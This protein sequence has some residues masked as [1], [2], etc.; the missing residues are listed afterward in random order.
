MGLVEFK[1]GYVNLC[2]FIEN[3]GLKERTH[4]IDETLKVHPFTHFDIDSWTRIWNVQGNPLRLPWTLV[5]QNEKDA[6]Y[7]LARSGPGEG[8][9][10][11]IGYFLGGTSIIMARASKERGREKVHAFD[12]KQHEDRENLLQANGVEDWISLSIKDSRQAAIDWGKRSDTRIRLLLVDGDHSYEGCKQD[13][14]SWVPYLV[15]GG[16]L[17]VHDYCNVS[18]GVDFSS[19]VRAV[20]D[21]VLLKSDFEDY[22]QTDTLF[23]ATKK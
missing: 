18:E 22:R 12:V 14:L 20:Y 4:I 1:E 23:L 10:V 9:I 3:L 2:R 16:I 8:E 11:N 5:S 6:L 13:I 19:I 15:P 7:E 21:T 17:A